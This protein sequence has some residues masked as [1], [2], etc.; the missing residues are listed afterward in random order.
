MANT[1]DD[2]EIINRFCNMTDEQKTSYQKIIDTCPYDELVTSAFSFGSMGHLN[3]IL[4]GSKINTIYY[5]NKLLNLELDAN[6]SVNIEF[7]EDKEACIEF[8]CK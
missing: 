7:I 1:Y 8:R 5:I 3:I 2:I 4:T 6:L